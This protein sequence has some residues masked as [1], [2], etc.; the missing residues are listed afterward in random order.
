M[1]RT[2]LVAHVSLEAALSKADAARA[3]D[4]VFR[5]IR[6]V[7]SDGGELRMAG[8]ATF[9]VSERPASE[10]RNPRTGE[11]ITIAASKQVKFKPGLELKRAVNGLHESGRR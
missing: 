8:F 5:A 6:Q 7:L 1:N 4:E 10:G 11:K 2:D 3:V 9:S